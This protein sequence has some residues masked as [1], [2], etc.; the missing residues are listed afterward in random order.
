MSVDIINAWVEG[1]K[2]IPVFIP[3]SMPLL[4]LDSAFE[5]GASA[6]T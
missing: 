2:R 3:S 4:G 5:R 1:K 6:V